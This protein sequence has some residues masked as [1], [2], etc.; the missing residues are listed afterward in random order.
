MKTL[1]ALFIIAI[2]NFCIG[3]SRE[4]YYRGTGFDTLKI[5]DDNTFQRIGGVGLAKSIEYSGT[6]EKRN[7]TLIVVQ[8]S[9]TIINNLDTVFLVDYERPMIDTFLILDDLTLISN[10]SF[11]KIINEFQNDTLIS[12]YQWNYID[13]IIDNV[14][15]ND[16]PILRQKKN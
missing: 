8:T 12:S 11:Y 2:S 6:I 7:D 4:Y 14:M 9:P 10:G 13:T 15:V 5:F 1:F 16:F 3:Q